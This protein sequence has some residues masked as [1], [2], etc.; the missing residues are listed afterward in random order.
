MCKQTTSGHTKISLQFDSEIL[1]AW[2][3]IQ[4]AL[5]ETLLLRLF[6][7]TNKKKINLRTL[8]GEHNYQQP[9]GLQSLTS[10]NTTFTENEHN[11]TSFL[12]SHKNSTPGSPEPGK[13]LALCPLHCCREAESCSSLCLTSPKQFRGSLLL[14]HLQAFCYANVPN[15]L[16]HS[17]SKM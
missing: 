16:A 4:L 5:K 15:S 7:L 10:R 13:I 14:P 3:Q 2:Q 17:L 8:S 12:V 6:A 9:V 11:V 1:I